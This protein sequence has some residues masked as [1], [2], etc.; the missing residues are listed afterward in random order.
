MQIDLP[1]DMEYLH[2]KKGKNLLKFLECFPRKIWNEIF[3]KDLSA[4]EVRLIKKF[5]KS[6]NH[7]F[8]CLSYTL[9]KIH[10]VSLSL[11]LSLSH[12]HTHFLFIYFSQYVVAVS[13][14]SIFS[15]R[16]SV[17]IDSSRSVPVV[18][19]GFWNIWFFK[20]VKKCKFK[21]NFNL[22]N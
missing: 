14:S 8:L 12:T 17:C 21:K 20:W 4:T 18:V 5:N 9:K 3:D 1:S 13:L 2:L 22:Q 10:T 11:S 6:K 16:H 19:I 15:V 7:F